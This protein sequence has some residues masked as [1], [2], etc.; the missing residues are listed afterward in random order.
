MTQTLRTAHPPEGLLRRMSS[1]GRGTLER[2]ES[3]RH[4]RRSVSVVRTVEGLCTTPPLEAMKGRSPLGADVMSLGSA[5]EAM[6]RK[7][8]H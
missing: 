7:A 2:G 8:V 6:W 5:W 1:L 3:V 4:A